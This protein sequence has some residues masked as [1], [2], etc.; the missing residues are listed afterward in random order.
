MAQWAEQLVILERGRGRGPAP[1]WTSAPG[2]FCTWFLCFF[3]INILG[4]VKFCITT[5]FKTFKAPVSSVFYDMKILSWKNPISQELFNKSMEK[6]YPTL[7]FLSKSPD[8]INVQMKFAFKHFF[9]QKE[10]LNLFSRRTYRE[11][12]DAC[13]L[14]DSQIV[15][16]ERKVELMQRSMS[17]SVPQND[18]L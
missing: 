6:K 16:G 8:S 15:G 7:P 1:G 18:G 12:W 5:S 10:S 9:E 11:R 2:C 14:T 3:L 13:A 4:W 17:L